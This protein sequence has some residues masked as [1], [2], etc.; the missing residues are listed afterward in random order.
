RAPRRPVRLAASAGGE[1]AVPRDLALWEVVGRLLGGGDAAVATTLGQGRRTEPGDAALLDREAPYAGGIA[2]RACRGT[3]RGL[4]PL[5]A[6]GAVYDDSAGSV[7]GD[8]EL[9]RF[10][11][12]HRLDPD[13]RRARTT[14]RQPVERSSRDLQP[15]P[16]GGDGDL[17]SGP[18]A[19]VRDRDLDRRPPTLG[20]LEH[21]LLLTQDRDLAHR[22]PGRLVRVDERR[23]H[24]VVDGGPVRGGRGDQDAVPRCARLGTPGGGAV[25][26]EMVLPD[27]RVRPLP[28]VRA[29]GRSATTAGTV[30][31]LDRHF[32]VIVG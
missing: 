16:L 6:D 1:D 3:L 11:A 18:G 25:A 24:R 27:V 30:A 5:G 7:S 22:E 23:D 10:L 17:A 29:G 20:D 32:R 28:L 21:L 2:V 4:D 12:T 13:H 19:A 15:P 14:L 26:E 8:A 31:E 9:A